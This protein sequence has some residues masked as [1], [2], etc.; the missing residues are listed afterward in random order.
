MAHH[1]SSSKKFTVAIFSGG[2]GGHVYPALATVEALQQIDDQEIVIIWFGRPNSF[3]SARVPEHITFVELNVGGIMGKSLAEKM[4]NAVSIGISTLTAIFHTYVRGVD[5]VASFGGYVGLTGAM[6]CLVLRRPL[7][8]HEQ[9]SL[10][11]QANRISSRWATKVLTGMRQ[12]QPDLLGKEP[13]FVGNPIRHELQVQAES[14][15]NKDKTV[16]ENTCRILVFGGSQGAA[17]INKSVIDA[18]SESDD[19][20][21]WL[22]ITGPSQYEKVLASYRERGIEVAS[23]TEAELDSAEKVRVQPF[24]EDMAQAFLW[25]HIAI[26]RAGAMTLAELAVFELPAVLI[27][28]ANSIHD[29][30]RINAESWQE[31]GAGTCILESELTAQTLLDTIKSMNLENEYSVWRQNAKASGSARSDKL[32][33]Q[34]I[35]DSRR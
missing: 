22:H 21:Q 32:V 8:V 28:L 35:A 34:Q 26:C 2:T 13:V 5:V 15:Q 30:Q 24:I 31:S 19:R 16:T 18:I 7:V 6:A 10:P 17:V 4:I 14:S 1:I 25:S 11:G 29:H 27:P 12:Q 23:G 3:E 9:N 20:W 33:A